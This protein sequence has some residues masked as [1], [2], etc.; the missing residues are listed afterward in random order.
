MLNLREIRS[1][2]I[3]YSYKKNNSHLF[4]T[5]I[6]AINASMMVPKWEA[7]DEFPVNHP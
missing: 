4:S 1:R 2:F 5:T 7:I 3:F 6:W